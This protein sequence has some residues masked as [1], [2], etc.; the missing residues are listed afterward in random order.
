M[1]ATR[2]YDED[3]FDVEKSFVALERSFFFKMRPGVWSVDAET[4]GKME[5]VLRALQRV[6]DMLVGNFTVSFQNELR[7]MAEAAGSSCAT[8]MKA[9]GVPMAQAVKHTAG[10]VARL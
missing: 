2:A 7:F 6:A 5:E 9:Q 10:A 1:P 3:A 4:A 8:A